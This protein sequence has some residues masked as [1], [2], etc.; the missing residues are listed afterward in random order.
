MSYTSTEFEKYNTFQAQET[1]LDRPTSGLKLGPGKI[2]LG[3]CGLHLDLRTLYFL[4]VH[5]AFSVVR[6][7]LLQVTSTRE[8]YY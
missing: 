3:S 7:R 5:L 8:V 4:C 6:N 1:L 2:T